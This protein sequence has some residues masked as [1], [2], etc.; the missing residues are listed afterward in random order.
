MLWLMHSAEHPFNFNLSLQVCIPGCVFFLSHQ[1]FLWGAH[2]RLDCWKVLRLNIKGSI[3]CIFILF[4]LEGTGWFHLWGGGVMAPWFLFFL[5]QDQGGCGPG[6]NCSQPAFKSCEFG[7]RRAPFLSC[8]CVWIAKWF[9][10]FCLCCC[11]SNVK[12]LDICCNF[13]FCGLKYVSYL[14]FH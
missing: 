12:T 3:Y 7:F 13:L 9:L 6:D 14:F 1:L 8:S 4:W 11:F 2:C 10:Q 5:F